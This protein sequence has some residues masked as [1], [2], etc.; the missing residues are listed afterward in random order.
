VVLLFAR[1]SD[2]LRGD[3][4]SVV[5]SWRYR[6]MV[7]LEERGNTDEKLA[8]GICLFSIWV[9]AASPP[10]SFPFQVSISHS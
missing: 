10:F 4:G 9:V 6:V 1:V 3:V 7:A 8:S 5:E 2:V